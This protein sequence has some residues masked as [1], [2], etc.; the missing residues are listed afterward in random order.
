[1][2]TLIYWTTLYI[3]VPILSPYLESRGLSY[4]LVGVI[5]GSYGFVQIFVR[6]P[7]GIISDKLRVRRPFLAIG[8]ATG[9]LSCLLF[10]ISDQWGWTLAARA[11][12]GVSASC[13]VAFTVLYAS[14]YHKNDATL[15]MGRIS[16]LTVCGQLIGMGLSGLLADHWGWNSAFWTG[17]V[18]GLVGLIVTFAIKEP[19]EGVSRIPIEVK[20]LVKVM[21]MPTLLKV[22]TLSIL[23]HCI[24]FIT[25]FGFTPSLAVSLGASKTELSLLVFAFMI[26]HAAAAFVTSRWIVPKIGAWNSVLIGFAVSSI[27]TVALALAPSFGWLAFSQIFN[28][29]AQGMHLPL[30]LG[31][32]I[33]SIE[34]S[35]R[36][37]AMGFYQSVYSIGMFAGP[38]LAGWLNESFGL[39]SG[40]YLGGVFGLIAIV[41][42]RIWTYLPRKNSS[43][44]SKKPSTP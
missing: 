23:A 7:L 14:Y 24:L 2:V 1:M 35:K 6:L 9:A 43:T 3:Y 17:A 37:T 34:I 10:A 15:A 31:L 16:T 20:D 36:A 28:G 12:S 19:E 11:V 44:T 38:F 18:I 21:R 39:V 5:L 26:P 40:F 32:S 4:L 13:W 42:T 41:L 22:S 30:L 8:L 33:Q 25:M 29:F 27:C